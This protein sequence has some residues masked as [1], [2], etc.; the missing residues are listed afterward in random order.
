MSGKLFIVSASSGAGKTTLVN[1]LLQKIQ[2]LYDVSRVLTYTTRAPRQGETNGV[3]YHFITEQTFE[4]LIAQGFF[5]E[6]SKDYG[7]YYGSP[8][9][10]LDE[11]PKGKSYIAILDRAGAQQ[12]FSRFAESVLIW[13]YT[14]IQNLRIRLESRKT[15]NIEQINYRIQLAKKEIEEENLKKFYTYHLHN[16][17][18]NRA[19]DEFE[20]L[21]TSM[22]QYRKNPY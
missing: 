20:Q 7:A 10:L 18:F 9:S 16:D 17:D 8:L 22:M 1:M 15:E 19:I 21:V 12:V 3:D 6:W 4:N 14:D 2:P 11:L 5:L 13:V